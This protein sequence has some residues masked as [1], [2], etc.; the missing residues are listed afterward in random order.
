MTTGTQNIKIQL[1]GY[2]R[3]TLTHLFMQ[4]LLTEISGNRND[5][6]E[7]NTKILFSE[8]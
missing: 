3:Y 8:I 5:E 6:S 7:C 1:L 2:C 4:Q